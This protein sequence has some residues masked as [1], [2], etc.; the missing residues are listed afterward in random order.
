MLVY[1]N[2]QTD[3]IAPSRLSLISRYIFREALGTTLIVMTV[4]LVIL[5]S[6][7]FAEILGDA[8]SDDLPREAVFTV[9]GLTFLRYLTLLAPIALLLGVLL[10]LAR[11]NRDSEMAALAACGIGT[12]A[13]LRPI[14]ALG[15]LAAAGVTWLAL[16]QAPGAS[17]EIQAIK[18]EAREQMELGALT[19]GS[20]ST[21]GA[22]GTVLYVREADDDRLRG[23]FMQTETEDGVVVVVADEGERVRDPET[24]ELS[25]SLKNSRRYEGVPGE[26]NF[27]VAEFEEQRIPIQV[28]R[29]EFVEGIDAKPTSMLIG[30]SN[31]ED[32]AELEWRMAAPLSTLLLVLLALP[33]SRSAPREGRFA[34]VGVGLLIY[35]IYSNTLSIARVWVERG[36]APEWLGS[37]WVHAALA[38]LA[39]ALLL[40]ESG[41]FARR[42]PYRYPILERHEPVA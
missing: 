20:F 32:R 29:E 36:A 41:A 39:I 7:Q 35:I 19:P 37:W 28:Q 24:G 5:M 1:S 42:R 38:L 4:L 10:A 34:R 18:Y 2:R 25:L 40:R 13:L 14:G 23:V 33:L 17:R 30:S 3:R 22:D 11:L 27:F 16:F 8:A 12:R 6:N 21:T 9:F 26:A 31:R 15:V